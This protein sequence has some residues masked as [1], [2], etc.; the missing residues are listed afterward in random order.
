[1]YYS[2]LIKR[3]GDII[4]KY[5]EAKF[6]VPRRVHL[7]VRS[8]VGDSPPGRL[9]GTPNLVFLRKTSIAKIKIC[10]LGKIVKIGYMLVDNK[11]SE[12]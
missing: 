4:L 9:F 1:M 5:Q 7:S 3:S 11:L 10:F 12:R 8:K 6:D 2:L